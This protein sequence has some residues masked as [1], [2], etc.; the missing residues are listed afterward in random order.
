MI[1]HSCKINFTIYFQI[2]PWFRSL[3]NRFELNFLYFSIID[4]VITNKQNDFQLF[5]N[6]M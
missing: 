5:M 1:Q 4:F 6:K 2:Y 3:K